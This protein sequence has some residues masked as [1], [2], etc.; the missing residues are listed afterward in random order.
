MNTNIKENFQIC[1]SVPLI[2]IGWSY[3]QNY[4]Y[5]N[6]KNISTGANAIIRT[7]DLHAKV[8]NNSS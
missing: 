7:T 3:P 8:K 6:G 2:K 1:I 5:L 4:T